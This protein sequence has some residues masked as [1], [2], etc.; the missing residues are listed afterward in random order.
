MNYSFSKKKKLEIN[1]QKNDK[2]AT[3]W[4]GGE[5]DGGIMVDNHRYCRDI[6]CYRCS[7]ADKEEEQEFGMIVFQLWQ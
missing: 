7:F 1:S 5:M 6:S 4:K 2:K 3:A